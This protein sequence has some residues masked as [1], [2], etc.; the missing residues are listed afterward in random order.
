MRP[1]VTQ[2]FSTCA[3]ILTCRHDRKF[4]GEEEQGIES[5]KHD[6]FEAESQVHLFW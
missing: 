3:D 1:Y 6:S 4:V 5:H 2:G